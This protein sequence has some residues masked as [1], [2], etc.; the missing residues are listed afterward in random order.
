MSSDLIHECDRARPARCTGSGTWTA[1]SA[2]ARESSPGP[3]RPGRSSS[4][5]RTGARVLAAS[6]RHFEIRRAL[7]RGVPGRQADGSILHWHHS[8][9]L[10][11]GR[12]RPGR[13][14]C[15][16][17]VTDVSG[18]RQIE[19]ALRLSEKRYRTLF[20]RN[21]AGVYRSTL[22]GRILDCNESFARIFGYASREEVLQQAAWD[23]YVKPEDRQA[24]A[25]QAPRAPDPDQLRA[26]PEAQG[27]QP[28]L[29]PREREP[30]RGAGRPPLGHRGNDDRHHRAQARRGAGQAPRLPRSADQPAEPAALQRPPDARRRPG[31]PPQP[32]ARRPLPRPRP[33]QGHQ[34]L[35]RPLGRRRAAPPGR[36]A[37]PGARPRGRHRRAP[38]RRRV[39]APRAG[40]HGRGRRRQDRPEDLRRDPR[41]LLDRRPRAL[42]HDEHG[43]RRL[44]VRRPRRR[45]AGPQRRLGDVPGQGAGPRQLPALHARDERQGRRAALAREPPAPGRRQRRARAPL[46]ALLRPQHRRGARRRGAAPLAAPRAGPDPAGRVHPHRR[47]LRA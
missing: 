10:L 16:G 47:A 2:I 21:L 24:A 13:A 18:R 41:P 15:I 22:E 1:S 7:L 20:E 35:A 44:P 11:R 8:A 30:H 36:R 37:H 31:A 19:E 26:L 42:R 3:S 23:F 9:T 34:R 14:L 5:R 45:D 32:E 12:G 25:G 40:H 28:R 38:R 29:G 17:T 39:H 6:R 43:R 4:T 46:P 27:R 33:L